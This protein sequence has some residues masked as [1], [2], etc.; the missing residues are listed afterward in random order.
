MKRS[1][2]NRLA[3]SVNYKDIP[4]MTP[5]RWITNLIEAARDLADKEKQ[6]CRWL[7]P[8]A[9][10]WERPEEAI[11]SFCDDCVFDL[12]IE[13]YGESFSGEQRNAAFGLR[14]ALNAFCDATPQV[15]DPA[16]TLA[17]PRWQL[18]RQHAAEF[19]CAFKGKWPGTQ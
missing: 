9:Y 15:L 16:A 2:K 19:V 12:Y 18:V 7:A 3:K 4:P 5:E 1:A 11:N 13:Q 6:E 10:A 17:D 14:D 8:D